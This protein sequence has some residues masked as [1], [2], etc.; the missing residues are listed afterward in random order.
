MR[1]RVSSQDFPHW[2]VK[3]LALDRVKYWMDPTDKEP[4][5]ERRAQEEA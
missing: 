4:V 3:L 1:D 5:H 2:Q